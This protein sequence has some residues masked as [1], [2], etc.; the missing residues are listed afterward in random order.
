MTMKNTEINIDRRI[1]KI[2][3]SFLA[4]ER[5]KWMQIGDKYYKCKTD[6]QNRKICKTIQG[7]QIEETYKANNKISHAKYKNLVDE[8]L[9]Y[10]LSKPYTLKNNEDDIEYIEKVK[11]ILGN[12]FPYT[13]YQ[14]G[15]EASNKGI[16][17][18]HVYID[19]IGKLKF[20][21]IPCEQ[22][23]PIWT[24]STHTELSEFIR[25]YSSVEWNGDSKTTTY[26]IEH[27]TTK[28]VTHY[29]Q[30]KNNLL[31][32]IENSYED[33]APISHYKKNGEWLSWG[34]IPFI[35]FKN[36]MVEMPDIQFIKSI[37]DAYDLTRS[38][39][40]NYI[41][42]VKNLIF[43][44]KG[45]G[46]ADLN[47]FMQQLN[48]SRAV[49]LDADEGSGLSALN[50][51][52]DITALRE[53]YEQLKRDILE[54]GQ[55]VNKDLDKFGS[56]PSG[57]A[58]KFMYAGLDLKC[59]A[60]ETEFKN[61]FSELGYF[62]DMYLLEIGQGD[63]RASDI[64]IEFNRNMQIDETEIINNC[65]AS[66]GTISDSTILGKHPWVKDVEK[67]L[68]R[69]EEELKD[70]EPEWNK[71]PVRGTGNGEEQIL[72]KQDSE[73]DLENIQQP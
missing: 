18:L 27:W 26:N 37:I 44:L 67:E 9:A 3:N 50:P 5:L 15:Y 71:V 55:G 43:V 11:N 29:T 56:A 4:S 36:N 7:K 70:N 47:E 32:D 66:K 16:G 69:L 10:L 34:K 51:T 58:L 73:R 21:V 39:A 6:I 25:R 8:K 61:G 64:D 62:L 42:E 41:E 23:I 19:E 65:I 1:Y 14:L 48:E 53:H 72:G 38:E 63:Y 45:Y 49:T 33:N 40:A 52:M 68:D 30:Q 22:C 24:D 46:G 12:K 59:N 31:L 28:G 54:D 13:L 35:F 17:W 20:V 60:M 2:I 57:V